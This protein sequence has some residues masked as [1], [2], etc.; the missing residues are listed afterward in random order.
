MFALHLDMFAFIF[1]FVANIDC[2]FFMYFCAANR[3]QTI[4]L[5]ILW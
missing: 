5:N 1:I 2:A 4:K 3:K